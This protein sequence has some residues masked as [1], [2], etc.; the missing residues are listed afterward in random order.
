MLM[1]SDEAL[2]TNGNNSR[3]ASSVA[4]I[5]ISTPGRHGTPELARLRADA[6]NALR[7]VAGAPGR[8]TIHDDAIA[9]RRSPL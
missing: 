8:S 2:A 9:E 6:A 3:G 1:G 4:A 5:I 7:Q